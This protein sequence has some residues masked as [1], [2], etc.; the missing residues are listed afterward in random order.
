MKKYNNKSENVKDWTTQHLK[1]QAL[2]VHS[3]I[4]VTEC[5]ASHDLLLLEALTAELE[6]R[7]YEV[8]ETK[9]LCIEKA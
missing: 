5:F 8:K 3:A 7:G 2:S 4:Y 1:S 9:Y 6:A